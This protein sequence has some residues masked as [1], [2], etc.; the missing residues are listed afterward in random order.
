DRPL[1]DHVDKDLQEAWAIHGLYPQYGWTP[2]GK[3]IVIW[4]EGKIW[5]ADVATGQGREIPFTAHVDQTINDAVRFPQ[6]VFTSD[7]QP[8]VLRDVAPSPA[9]RRVAYGALGHIS[10][11]DLPSGEPRRLIRPSASTTSVA[12]E[13]PSGPS[14]D[15]QQASRPVGEAGFEFHPAWSADGQSIVFTTW[16]DQDLGRVRVVRAD[17]SGGRDVVTRPGHYTEAAFSPDGR[18]IVFRNAGA[19]YIRGNL[20]GDHPGIYVVPADG[21]AVPRLV[22]EG[23]S[24]PHFDHTG[25]RIYVTDQ[26]GPKTVLVSVGLGDA[27]AALAAKDEIVHFQS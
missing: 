9:G 14:D 4:G 13:A 21:S 12:G 18:T 15:P 17:G 19:D 5:R 26:N 27:D 8:K 10:T 11:K 7:L 25:K 22:R 2:D 24:D 16:S 1:F 3:S 6:K 20:Y 23:G